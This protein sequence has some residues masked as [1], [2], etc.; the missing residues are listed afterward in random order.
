MSIDAYCGRIKHVC[1]RFAA[2]PFVVVCE[3]TFDTRPPDQAYITGRIEWANGS[4]LHWKE[5]LDAS[6]PHDESKLRYSYHVQDA[7]KN[8]LFRYDNALHKPTLPYR[9][10][11]HIGTDTVLFAPAPTLEDVAQE[12]AH[13]FGWL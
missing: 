8:L 6:L 12:C 3:V 7:A 11:K 1:D 13:A 10:H 4:E 5:Y 2:L 9:E